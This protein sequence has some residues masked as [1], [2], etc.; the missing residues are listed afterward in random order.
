M[1][2]FTIAFRGVSGPG[3]GGEYVYRVK[4]DSPEA[5]SAAAWVKAS[6]PVHRLNRGNTE[7]DPTPSAISE[8]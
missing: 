3:A 6:Q 4:A 7:L 8:H 2:T 1:S 5:A